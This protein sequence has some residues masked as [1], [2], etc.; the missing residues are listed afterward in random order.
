MTE[1]LLVCFGA[2]V[3]LAI[4]VWIALHRAGARGRLD[5][6][7]RFDPRNA[8]P[9]L[10]EPVALNGRLLPEPDATDEDAE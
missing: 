7:R 6:A 1:L 2:G 4:P 5:G 9:C 10:I 8:V 3:V